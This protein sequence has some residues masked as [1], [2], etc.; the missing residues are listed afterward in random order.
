MSTAPSTQNA[1]VQDARERRASLSLPY[2][3]VGDVFVGGAWVPAR[4]TGRNPVTDPA[5]GEV[6]RFNGGL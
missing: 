1:P 3:R 2:A 6:V 5:T 4:G